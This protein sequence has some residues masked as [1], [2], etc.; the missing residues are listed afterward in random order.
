MTAQKSPHHMTPAEYRAALERLGF[1]GAARRS[2]ENDRGLSAAARF[3]NVTPRTGQAWALSGP[4]GSVAIA[5]RLMLALG[6]TLDQA[7]ALISRQKP[8]RD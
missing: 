7:G 3:F 8:S 6:L 1:A 2:P 4:P 5:L